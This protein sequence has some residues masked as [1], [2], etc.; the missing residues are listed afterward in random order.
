[1]LKTKVNTHELV[2]SDFREIQKLLLQ[3]YGHEYSLDY[4]RKVCKG[5][6]N[7]RDIKKM[8]I[9]YTVVV[10]EMKQKLD[11]LSKK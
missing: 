6:R 3:K 4:I 5:K 9:Q 1:M 2:A 10:M 8:A 7:N 11:E